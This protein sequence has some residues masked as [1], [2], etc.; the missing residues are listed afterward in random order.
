MGVLAEP[1]RAAVGRRGRV[2]AGAAELVALAVAGRAPV[3]PRR[4]VRASA[5]LVVPLAMVGRA[6]LVSGLRSR[7]CG[8][9]VLGPGRLAT[10]TARVGLL[11]RG[12]LAVRA[13][14]QILP[15]RARHSA[16]GLAVL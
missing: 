8:G 13:G 1:R 14:V 15:L 16:R 7:A 11:V 4:G 12:L 9:R 6:L 3:R 10:L 2:R 5:G